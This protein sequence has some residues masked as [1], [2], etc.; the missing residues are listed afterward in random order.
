MKA[1]GG[2]LNDGLVHQC[3]HPGTPRELPGILP[4]G[5]AAEVVQARLLVDA[6]NVPGE[7]MLVE[8]TALE[9]GTVDTIE[10]TRHRQ[11]LKLLD[12]VAVLVQRLLVTDTV[13]HVARIIAVLVKLWKMEDYIAPG[14]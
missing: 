11:A 10:T 3:L 8:D 9:I 1:V 6:D 2:I 14:Q 5:D 7:V 4:D 12:D 13:A